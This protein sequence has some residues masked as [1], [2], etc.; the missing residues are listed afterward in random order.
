MHFSGPAVLGEPS[1]HNTEYPSRRDLNFQAVAGKK[2]YD[3]HTCPILRSLPC[4][5]G[6]VRIM[7][8]HLEPALTWPRLDSGGQLSDFQFLGSCT[9]ATERWFSTREWSS[10]RTPIAEA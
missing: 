8:L 5:D 2:E 7:R 4:V 10:D 3:N 6:L 9:L 1:R